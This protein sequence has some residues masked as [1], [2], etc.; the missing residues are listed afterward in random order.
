[1]ASS[2]SFSIRVLGPSDVTL[3]VAL[4]DV[5]GEAFDSVSTHRDVRPS[6]GYLEGLLGSDY[7]IAVV[8]VRDG[9]V[10]G[11]LA[12]YELKK[13]EQERSEVYIYDLAVA[14]PHRRLGI[15]TALLAEVKRIAAAQGARVVFLQADLD[16]EPAIALYSKLGKREDVVQ[17]DIE[18]DA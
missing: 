10:V 14:Q 18:T 13:Y 5:F 3:M 2:A 17:F 16:D 7:F 1:M 15:A 12:G 6:G 9:E 11:G 8:A 4:N